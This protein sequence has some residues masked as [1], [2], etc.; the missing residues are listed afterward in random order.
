MGHKLCLR[1]RWTPEVQLS[2]GRDRAGTDEVPGWRVLFAFQSSPESPEWVFGLSLPEDMFGERRPLLSKAP[3]PEMDSWAE[4][5]PGNSASQVDLEG[6]WT[7]ACHQAKGW[8]RNKVSWELGG[9]RDEVYFDWHVNQAMF[10]IMQ[11]FPLPVLGEASEFKCIDLLLHYS[12]F[13][14]VLFRLNRKNP[15]AA[16]HWKN[17][18]CCVKWVAVVIQCSEVT[19]CLL[20]VWDFSKIL[21]FF[22]F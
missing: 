10:G 3:F 11:I 1:G 5:S 16:Y 2:R 22:F 4:P 9:S 7:S 18:S 14:P 12:I 13:I 6:R 17:R 15:Q 21:V 8:E 20:F 19:T